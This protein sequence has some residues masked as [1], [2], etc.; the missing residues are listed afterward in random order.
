MTMRLSPLI[1]CLLVLTSP[2]TLA[3]T[4][5]GFTTQIALLNATTTGDQINPG[6]AAL[7]DNR[8]VMVYEDR[9]GADGSSSGILGGIY[10]AQNQLLHDCGVMNTTTGSF[11]TFPHVAAAPD[12]TFMVVWSNFTNTFGQRFSPTCEKLGDETFLGATFNGLDVSADADGNFWVVRSKDGKAYARQYSNAGALLIDDVLLVEYALPEKPARTVSAVLATGDLLVTWYNKD[13]PNSSDI[14]GL[15][16]SADGTVTNQPFVIN[17]TTANNQV[18]PMI[19]PLSGGGFVAVW[20]SESDEGVSSILGRRFMSDGSAGDEFV[21]SFT[22]LAD[23]LTPYIVARV[24]GGFTVGW[25]DHS[26]TREVYLYSYDASGAPVGQRRSASFDEIAILTANDN[27]EMAELTSG[28]LVAVWSAT[29]DNNQDIFGR[30]LAGLAPNLLPDDDGDGVPNEFD[31]FPND[32]NETSDS[33][34]DGLGDNTDAFPFDSSETIDTDND[35]IGNNADDD[36]DNDGFTDSAELAAGTDPLDAN[37]YPATTYTVTPSAG[38][39]GSISPSTAQTVEEGATRSFTLTPSSGYQIDAVG[40]T[41][42][43]TLSGSTYTTA[44]VTQDCTVTASF[45]ELPATTYTVT[46]SA[47]TGGSISPSSAQTVEEGATTSF[48]LM[49]SSG[50]QIDTVGGTCSGTLSGSTYTTAAVTQNCTVAA[51]FSELPISGGLPAW[52]LYEASKPNKAAA[53]N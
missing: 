29:G 4:T 31:A 16:V 30:T 50:Y 33:D 7:P 42:G 38:T 12:G 53:P 19:A 2:F 6:V 46:P 21:V 10:D 17:A 8:F 5:V 28:S 52:L 32:A 11:Q 41:C 13:N 15:Y 25:T 37:S 26:N 35:G 40:G 14:Y 22:S 49:P 36:D 24:G 48:T 23:Q 3:S 18:E 44:A 39:G 9:A 45:A 43:G 47:G 1:L 34:G 51:E 20:A 27:V